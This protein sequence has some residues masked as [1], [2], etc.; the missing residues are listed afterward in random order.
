MSELVI[1]PLWDKP[2]YKEPRPVADLIVDVVE[3]TP[4][5]D[6]KLKV[7]LLQTV[8]EIGVP[9][10]I[11]DVDR[12]FAR[13]E[14]LSSNSAAY[15][16]EFNAKKYSKLIEIGA[17]GRSG[18]SSKYV[19]ATIKKLSQEVIIVVMNDEH[20][21]TIERK[22]VRIAL[23]AAGYFVQDESLIKLPETPISGPNVAEYQG[24]DF[25]V[26]LT[27]NNKEKVNVR[28]LL[29]HKGQPLRLDWN[30]EP[31]Y[32]LLEEQ[33]ELL[34]SMYAKPAKSEDEFDWSLT[35]AKVFSPAFV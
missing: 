16:N 18:P 14:L 25:A 3:Q 17:Q 10:D 1:G 7:I 22:H 13:F 35:Q 9:G 12:D 19:N 6:P 31:R 21:W 26:E 8:D 5:V 33:A 20:S 23:R 4:V 24:K 2:R 34:E 27:I 15:Y 32:P 11:V 28:C 30:T 29:H